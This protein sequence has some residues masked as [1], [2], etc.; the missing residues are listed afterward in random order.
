VLIL[1]IFLFKFFS[2]I[3]CPAVPNTISDRWILWKTDY[4]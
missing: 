1:E 2:G 4:C 3:C